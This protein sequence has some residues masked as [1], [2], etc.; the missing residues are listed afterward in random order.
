MK[1][2]CSILGANLRTLRDKADLTQEEAS[3]RTGISQS[4][5]SRLEVGAWGKTLDNVERA[6]H[7]LGIDPRDLLTADLHAA[8]GA[9]EVIEMW[10]EVDDD[11]RGIVLAILRKEARTRAPKVD[12]NVAQSS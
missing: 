7:V 8:A 2:L 10:G 12:K 3:D 4:T 5:W 6:L 1:M 11:T 9:R